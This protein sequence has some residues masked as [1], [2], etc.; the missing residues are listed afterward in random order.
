[1]SSKSSTTP[2]APPGHRQRPAT[3]PAAVAAHRSG[4]DCLPGYRTIL[5]SR[6]IPQRVSACRLSCTDEISGKDTARTAGSFDALHITVSPWYD[7]QNHR[8]MHYRVTG[9]AHSDRQG[10]GAPTICGLTSIT[11]R[12]HVQCGVD[13]RTPR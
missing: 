7:N 4:A 8:V 3:V 6:R 11:C 5:T 1:V 10:L 2:P 9:L 12:S 13:H